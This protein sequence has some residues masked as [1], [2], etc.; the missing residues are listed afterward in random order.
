MK[1]HP[2]LFLERGILTECF[3]I[4]RARVGALL[5]PLS[6]HQEI[7]AGYPYIAYIS[8]I[9]PSRRWPFDPH[10]PGPSALSAVVGPAQ[11]RKVRGEFSLRFHPAVARNGIT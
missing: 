4:Y 1:E 5:G 2:A 8:Y 7:K 9:R 10:L 3:Q 6:S 11:A